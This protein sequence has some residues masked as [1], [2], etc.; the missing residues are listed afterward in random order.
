M[1]SC[2]KRLIRTLYQRICGFLKKEEVEGPKAVSNF[3]CGNLQGAMLCPVEKKGHLTSWPMVDTFMAQK[4]IVETFTNSVQGF[5]RDKNIFYVRKQARLGRNNSVHE[6][7]LDT[8]TLDTV[9][10]VNPRN[11][12]ELLGIHCFCPIDQWDT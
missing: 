6:R 10:F 9:V 2:I 11:V 7:P 4:L 3:G 1:V 12:D 5:H 8:L